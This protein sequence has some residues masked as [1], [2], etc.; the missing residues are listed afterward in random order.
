[1]KIL[2]RQT[3]ETSLT[4]V[5]A[6]EIGFLLFAVANMAVLTCV[7]YF[8]TWNSGFEIYKMVIKNTL[9]IY[10]FWRFLFLLPI[11]FP[12][13]LV[14]VVQ[15]AYLALFLM[16]YLYTGNIINLSQLATL[17]EGLE[18]AHT[19]LVVLKEPQLLILFLD[20]PLFIYV[21]RRYGAIRKELFWLNLPAFILGLLA[22]FLVIRKMDYFRATGVEW[23]YIGQNAKFGTIYTSLVLSGAAGE[24]EAIQLLEYGYQKGLAGGSE[25]PS[26][27]TIQVESLNTN[28]ISFRYKGVPVTP[29]LNRLRSEAIFYPYMIAQ[30]RSG[31]SSDA[32]FAVFNGIEA[33][34]GFPVCQFSQY[35]YPNSYLKR[36]E[37]YDKLAFHGNS[38]EYFNRNHNLPA[39]GFDHFYDL[40]RMNLPE[41][42]WGASDE[43]VFDWALARAS[44]TEKPFYHHIITMSSH[45]PFKLVKKYHTN[46][47]FNDI[48][49]SVERDYLLSMNYVDQVLQSYI[50]AMRQRYPETW[51]FIYSDH[52]VRIE[53]DHYQ[54]EPKI[55][56]QGTGFEFVPLFVVPPAGSLLSSFEGSR[57]ASVLD[58][59]LTLLKA[60]GITGTIKSWGSSLLDPEDISE[61]I[62]HGGRDF[63][64]EKLFQTAQ[65]HWQ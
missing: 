31:G 3:S 52:A 61:T 4:K 13:I 62:R 28:V 27:V 35:D 20:L 14:L 50:E 49:S 41:E 25:H 57:A 55:V 2:N 43:A 7:Q 59:N 37:G 24:S 10:C 60:A 29:Y 32:E 8:M 64:R 16:Y 42:G 19:F 15:K 12:S 1:M 34:I 9:F 47:L 30:H 39:M 44:E 36:L 26:I 46:P 23:G 45:G 11:R 56:L 58:M 54:A 51:F 53:G 22:L 33:L 18:A 48:E 17:S 63:N 65:E 21:F 40:Y 38:G 5:A 6:A